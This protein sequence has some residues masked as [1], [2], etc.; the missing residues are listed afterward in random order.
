MH[1]FEGEILRMKIFFALAK[2]LKD[3]LYRFRGKR[4]EYV[5]CFVFFLKDRIRFYGPNFTVGL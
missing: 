3:T 4:Q 1:I 5:L 2:H